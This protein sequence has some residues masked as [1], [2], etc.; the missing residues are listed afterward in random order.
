MKFH[1]EGYPTLIVILLFAAL[2]NLCIHKW[3]NYPVVV[4]LGYALSLFLLIT[5]VQFFR[6]PARK[7]VIDGNTI[8]SPADGKVVVIEEVTETEYFKDKRIQVSVFM[9]PVNVHVNR[10][11]I[12][13]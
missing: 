6:N 3:L 5:I 13:G 2:L 1:K 9:S 4:Y 11:P 8:V 7:V 12:G 10:F